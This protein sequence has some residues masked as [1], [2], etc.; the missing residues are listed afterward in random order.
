ME[1]VLI[2]L[3]V[4]YLVVLPIL[5]L[6]LLATT[7]DLQRRIEVLE[8]QGRRSS[9]VRG[10]ETPAR[11][12]VDV[13][14]APSESAP[15][16]DPD[17]PSER[18]EPAVRPPRPVASE[19][20]ISPAAASEP[21]EVVEGTPPPLPRERR[22]DEAVPPPRATPV[23]AQAGVDWERFLGVRGAAI[24]GGIA[25][26]LAGIFFVQVAIERGWLGPA[27]RDTLALVSGILGLAAHRPLLARGYRA[28]GESIGGAGAVL[29]YGAAWAA[30][31]LHG[32]VPVWL[33]LVLMAATT[34]T[35][36]LLAMR[37]RSAVLASFALI[38]GYAT[39]LLLD[40]VDGDAASL[41]GYVLVLDLALL[42]VARSRRWAWMLPLA[43][44]GTAVVQWA[45]HRAT[46]GGVNPWTT[47]AVLGGFSAVFLGVRSRA[48]DDS[49]TRGLMHVALGIAL[50]SPFFLA[51]DQASTPT[52][53]ETIWPYAALVAVLVTGATIAARRFE[54]PA[55]AIAGALLGA[56]MLAY[57]LMRLRA[58]EAGPPD[59]LWTSWA[60]AAVGLSVLHVA[61]VRIGGPPGS[62]YV[63]ALVSLGAAPLAALVESTSDVPWPYALTAGA[64]SAVGVWAGASLRYPRAA[65]A[66]VGFVA[67]GG[68]ALYAAVVI[69]EP[70]PFDSPVT[71]GALALALLALGAS[72]GVAR[73]TGAA[74]AFAAFVVVAP[75]FAL[76]DR[77]GEATTVLH[78]ALHALVGV[79]AAVALQR[80]R[81][82]TPVAMWAV[83][84]A[85]TLS[86]A[87]WVD[88]A[89]ENGWVGRELDLVLGALVTVAAVPA[90]VSFV[91]RT[92]PRA[93]EGTAW[94]AILPAIL[95]P[96]GASTIAIG[97]AGSLAGAH[98]LL[99]SGALLYV[100]P[101]VV[102][103]RRESARP[104]A[105]V[106]L[107][108][109]IALASVSLSRWAAAQWPTVAIALVGASFAA[110]HGRADRST[111]S[112]LGAAT[113]TAAAAALVVLTFVEGAFL[114]EPFY[115]PIHLTIDHALVATALVIAALGVRRLPEDSEARRPF[116]LAPVVALLVVLF[117]WANA[118]VLNHFATGERIEVEFERLQERDL[119]LSLAWALFGGALLAVGLARRAAGLRW[120]SLV[121]LLATV[122]KVFLYDLGALTGLARVGSFLGLAVC[123]LGVSLLYARVLGRDFERGETP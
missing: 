24:V 110:V 17:A 112:A 57:A 69:D 39:P 35:A 52:V 90:A 93:L 13:A 36:L 9:S 78:V 50:L 120:A 123:L 122:V 96:F 66:S 65:G 29:V 83:V 119:A 77:A 53:G 43:A 61:L 100:A 117:S 70:V 80:D 64:L 86:L 48:D 74:R 58:A 121:V 1:G 15:E 81:P 76:A 60:L 25:L 37:S 6:A 8:R 55:D 68:F 12:S 22:V 7:R 87:T 32:L 91:T 108:T 94:A 20:A 118:V 41:F 44:L 75:L 49:R 82:W 73:I 23:P 113:A 10:V 116:S 71:M 101:G 34:G 54:S 99:L 42:A 89:L 105:A 2:I 106:L 11:T 45:W 104:A 40:T 92:S 103:D 30:S 19:P 28:L 21:N 47:A 114:R 33:A 102:L 16:P 98:V 14:P 46:G 95:L 5:V 107:A 18:V 85:A 97:L 56:I 31:R 79:G 27:E 115:V 109:G 63:S 4:G 88:V 62:A 59:A 26:V 3:T 72:A 51:F 38:G 111:A 67:G 84:S